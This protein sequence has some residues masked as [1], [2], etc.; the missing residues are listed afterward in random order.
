VTRALRALPALLRVGAASITA[1]RAEMVVWILSATLPL[2]MMALWDAASREVELPGFGPVEVARYFAVM[3]VVRQLTGMWLVWEFNHQVR[4]GS[5]SPQLLRPLHPLWW[6]F[7]ETVA[8]IPW[9][10]AVLAPLM[11]G[12]IA[13]RPEIAWSP[14]P[15]HLAGFAASLVLAWSLGWAIQ[16][17][18]AML[19]FW[20][21]EALGAWNAW[22]FVWGLFGGYL[23]PLD[24]MPD[25]VGAVARWLPFRATIGA[26]VEVLLGLAPVGPTLALQTAWLAAFGLLARGMWRA[27]V[28]RY[29]AVGA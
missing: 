21:D 2:V 8:A 6:A 12:L 7:A 19:A 3:L 9:R 11:V 28:A 1:Y 22:F 23:V 18:F 5:L 4:T 16:S 24:L 20:F 15:T 10:M 27:G 14:A 26:P 25:A 29:G 13:W 17:C